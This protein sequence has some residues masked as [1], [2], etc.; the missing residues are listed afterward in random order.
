MGDKKIK[1]LTDLRY[2]NDMIVLMGRDMRGK[3]ESYSV[4][5]MPP[6]SVYTLMLELYELG[7]EDARK[8]IQDAISGSGFYNTKV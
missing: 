5:D 7:K 1:H 4:M 6:A 3:Q 2:F 8:D